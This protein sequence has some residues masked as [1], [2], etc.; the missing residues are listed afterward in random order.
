MDVVQGPFD[1]E[2]ESGW[3]WRV[4]TLTKKDL[5][6]SNTKDFYRVGGG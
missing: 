3:S 1:V 6:P 5:Q 2:L 4:T